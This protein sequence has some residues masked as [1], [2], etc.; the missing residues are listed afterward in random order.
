MKIQKLNFIILIIV[1]ALHLVPIQAQDLSSDLLG[2]INNLRAN[3]G[4]S[5]YT[6]HPAL[7]AAAQ[8]HA[9][10]M[11][12]TGSVD[13]VQENGSRPVDRAQANGYNSSWVSENIFMG[14]LATVDDAWNFWFNSSIHYAGM[15]SPNFDH[16]GIAMARGE[17]GQAFV[18]VFANSGSSTSR[19]NSSSSNSNNASAAPPPGII[20]NDESGN[21]QYELQPG[22]TLGDIL[23]LFGYTWD[24]LPAL[25]E[26]N[27]LTDADM[28]LL[29]VGQVILVP[30]AA[31]TWTPTPAE[32]RP[33]TTEPAVEITETLLE[34]ATYIESTPNREE[35]GQVAT[36]IVPSPTATATQ[37]MLISTAVPTLA[38][39]P[40]LSAKNLSSPIPRLANPPIWLVGA[41]VVQVGVLLYA[42]YELLKRW[43]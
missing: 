33:E 39:V 6:L 11:V 8:A 2:R 17:Y 19:T 18:L 30:P 5:P 37:V 3:L 36:F 22:D 43:R 1:F 25:L 16:I 42:G 31:G 27:T 38:L 10:W 24:D 9:Q 4:L 7:T 32:T 29:S 41:I 23:L 35:L 34:P 14:G 12:N 40:T 26:L 20:G 13:H 21:I 15:T 28:R